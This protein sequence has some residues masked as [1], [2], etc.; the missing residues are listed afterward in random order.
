MAWNSNFIEQAME[1]ADDRRH[2][3]CEITGIHSFML[4]RA[5][6][7]GVCLPQPLRNNHAPIYVPDALRST[8]QLS[9]AKE[10]VVKHFQTKSRKYQAITRVSCSAGV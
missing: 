2:L 9:E 5:L 1:L 3:C 10:M 8:I 7:R 4:I 6:L